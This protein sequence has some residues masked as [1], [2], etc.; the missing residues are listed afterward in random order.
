MKAAFDDDIRLLVDLAVSQFRTRQL[1]SRARA[2]AEESRKLLGKIDRLAV[3]ADLR[4]VKPPEP[5]RWPL[6]S[7]GEP[8]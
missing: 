7:P 8:A 6:A 2:T 3:R 5:S 1:L 4:P